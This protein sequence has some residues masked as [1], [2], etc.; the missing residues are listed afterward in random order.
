MC[1]PASNVSWPVSILRSMSERRCPRCGRSLPLEA[2]D[3]RNAERTR[4]QSYCRECAKS[5]WREWY[6]KEENRERHC[7]LV[8]E[9]RRAR[10]DRHR[11]IILQLKSRPCADCGKTFP[12]EAMDFDHIA[13]KRIEVSRLL[14]ISGT[15]TL[16]AEIAKCEVVCAN[17]HRVR[18]KRRLL[19]RRKDEQGVE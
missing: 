9:R 15:A 16:L 3:Y 1:L 10:I 8:R 19:E 12:P 6:A 4:L 14:Y 7:R 2:F 18:T 17:C 13:E 5:A 11:T